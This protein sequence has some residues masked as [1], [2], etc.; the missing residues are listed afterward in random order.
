MYFLVDPETGDYPADP[1]DGIS[2]FMPAM[3]EWLTEIFQ[4]ILDKINEQ[5]DESSTPLIKD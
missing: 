3:K 1:Y 2:W 4:K 5:E